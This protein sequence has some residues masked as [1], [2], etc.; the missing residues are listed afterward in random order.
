MDALSKGATVRVVVEYGRCQLVEGGDPR[1]APARI[2]GFTVDAWRS[3]IIGAASGDGSEVILA[4]LGSG[5]TFGEMSLLDSAGRSALSRA[6][7]AGHQ[8][9]AESLKA[10]GAV[11]DGRHRLEPRPVRP[12]LPQ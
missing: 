10:A 3:S 9:V 6:T 4:F 5:D 7:L 2:G 11:E 1:L 8:E 12:T